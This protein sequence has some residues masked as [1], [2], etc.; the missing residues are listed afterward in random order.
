VAV[1]NIVGSVTSKAATLT[2]DSAPVITTQPASQTV[3]A[4]TNVTFT[5]VATGLPA[6]TYQWFLNGAAVSGATKASLTINN[7]KAAN[8]GSYTVAVTNTLGS[9][10][11]NGATLV[12]IVPPAITTQPKSQTVNPGTNVT[13]TVV[14]TGTPTLAYQWTF[15][16]TAISG[17][18]TSAL[19]LNSV[20]VAA[21]G[22]YS[23]TVTNS[24]G[25]VTSNAAVLNVK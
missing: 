3:V 25:I 15:D 22:D 17:A 14:A 21:A 6:P 2:V 16:G 23:V 9:A 7:T 12:V 18:T 10:T 8:A 11:S 19:T 4:G 20:Q 13:F 24:G 5:V 1:T